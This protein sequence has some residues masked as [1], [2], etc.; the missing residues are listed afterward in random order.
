[1][2]FIAVAED[3]EISLAQSKAGSFSPSPVQIL[4]SLLCRLFSASF[5]IKAFG[6]YVES[7]MLNQP[8][9]IDEN[10]YVMKDVTNHH[11]P[12]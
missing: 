11:F 1:M 9:F 10:H 3:D 6:F 5:P 12:K 2:S 4:C 7:I 8:S